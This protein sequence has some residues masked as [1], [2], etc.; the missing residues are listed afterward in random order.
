MKIG[1]AVSEKKTFKDYTILYMYLAQGQ[2]PITPRES[3]IVSFSLKSLIHFEKMIFQHFVWGHK[4][5][6]AIKRSKVNL[7]L[8]SEQTR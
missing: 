6:F 2:G 7:G 5:D 1:R 4:F 8:S 3:Y